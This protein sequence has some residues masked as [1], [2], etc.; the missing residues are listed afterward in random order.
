M[1]HVLALAQREIVAYFLSPV[2]YVVGFLFI[3]LYNIFFFLGFNQLQDGNAVL[4]GGSSSVGTFAILA[5]PFL[6]MGLLA[7]EKRSGTI[8]MLMTA[9]VADWEVVLGKYLGSVTFILFLAAPSLVQLLI[10]KEYSRPEWGPVWVGYLGLVLL[11]LLLVA[12]GLFFSSISKSALVAV[13]TSFVVFVTLLVMGFFVPESPPTIEASNLF[14]NVTHYIFAFFK[15]ASLGEHYNNFSFGLMN[16]KD[17]VYF[18]SGAAFFLFLS[19]LAVE[20]R[21]WK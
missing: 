19:T 12:M 5:I 16:S 2:G 20:S 8:E 11:V 9:P 14:S 18:V 21:K 7:D 4:A 10:V 15:F 13:M 3:G 17:I 1:R 6:T